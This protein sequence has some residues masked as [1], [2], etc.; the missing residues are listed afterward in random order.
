ML[1]EKNRGGLF[2][3][4]DRWKERKKER[5]CDVMSFRWVRGL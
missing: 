1:N 5:R 3:D 4:M 2:N